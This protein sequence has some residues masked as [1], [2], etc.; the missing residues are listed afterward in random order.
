MKKEL[1]KLSH[2]SFGLGGYQ[3]A[4]IGLSVT[5]EGYAWGVSDNKTAWDANL[6]KHSERCKWS[7]SDRDKQYAEIMRYVSDLLRDAKVDSV[8]KLKGKP[9]EATFD[10]GIL[11]SWRILTEV[12]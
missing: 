6:I 10:D 4:C 9:V 5:I 3:D 1:G 11:K 8:E 12:L 7:E 2:V